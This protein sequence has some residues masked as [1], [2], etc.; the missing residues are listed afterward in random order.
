MPRTMGCEGEAV[1]ESASRRTAAEETE[2]KFTFTDVAAYWKKGNNP[3][4]QAGRSRL[5]FSGC[6][7]GDVDQLSPSIWILFVGNELTP[8]A[9]RI[10]VYTSKALWCTPVGKAGLRHCERRLA[11]VSLCGII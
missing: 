4:D 8:I 1:G 5:K 11:T 7:A 6:S 3:E 9:V 10:C 2:A